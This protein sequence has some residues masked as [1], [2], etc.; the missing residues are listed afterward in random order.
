MLASE[1]YEN[2]NFVDFLQKLKAWLDEL[3]DFEAWEVT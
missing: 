1:K 3:G 2:I